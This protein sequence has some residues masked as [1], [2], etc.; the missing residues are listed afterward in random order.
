MSVDDGFY[1]NAG[2]V[3]FLTLEAF[4]CGVQIVVGE[5]YR[6]LEDGGQ[7]ARGIGDG[8]G[9]RARPCGVQARVG[10]Y[11]QP[12]RPAVVASLELDHL[13]A[14]GIGSRHA[15]SVLQGVG[16]GVAKHALLGAGDDFTQLLG[17]L[18]LESMR[19]GDLNA[20]IPD[21]LYYDLVQLVCRV[22]QNNG[23]RSGVVVYV[24]VTV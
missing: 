6:V 16:A 14:A 23:A 9:T 11:G 3:A 24:L 10:A 12:V 8:V 13:L 7:Y 1:N 2:D 17:Q 4:A 19:L 21:G 20:D 15:H 5:H 18:H 22:A